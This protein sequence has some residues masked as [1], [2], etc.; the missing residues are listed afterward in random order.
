MWSGS[1]VAL[2]RGVPPTETT[3]LTHLIKILV[4]ILTYR[5]E[6]V[7][8]SWR[9]LLMALRVIGILAIVLDIALNWYE[10]WRT[11]SIG[12]WYTDT[13]LI[14]FNLFFIGYCTTL[15]RESLDAL[16]M[17]DSYYLTYS[18]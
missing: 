11:G 4:G 2:R 8:G 12:Y 9:I 1:A 10:W 15:S 7:R 3:R 16:A 13:K 6:D 18:S 14:L 5:L 17:Q